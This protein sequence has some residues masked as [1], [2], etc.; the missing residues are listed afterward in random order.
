MAILWELSA[1]KVVALLVA[2]ILLLA[3]Y[4]IKT[5]YYYAYQN[6]AWWIYF[7]G[8]TFVYLYAVHYSLSEGRHWLLVFAMLSIFIGYVPYEVELP[9]M[10]SLIINPEL[11]IST[12][13]R[14]LP[15]FAGVA[16]DILF[17]P[18]LVFILLLMVKKIT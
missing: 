11:N 18:L 8:I 5:I 17:Y 6:L 15:L 1:L 12:I 10:I 14:K 3:V 7:A 9:R 4:S 2:Y 13:F 16:A